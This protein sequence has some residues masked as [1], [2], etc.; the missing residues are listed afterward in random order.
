[1]KKERA[2][3]IDGNSFCYRAFYAIRTLSTSSGR[4]TNAVYGFVTM[5]QKLIHEEK[6]DYLAIA[7]DMKAETFRKKEFQDYKIH[8]KP[9]PDEL[10]EQLPV[11]QKVLGLYRIPIFQKEGYEADDVLGTLS[12]KLSAEGIAVYIVTGD[13]DILQLV[14]DSVFVYHSHKEGLI[15]DKK[16]VVE[17]FGIAPEKIVELIGLCG[18]SSDNIPGVPGV[19]E[20]TAVELIQKFGDLDRVLS[21]VDQVEGEARRRSLK[22]YSEQARLSRRLAVIDTEVPV[23]FSLEA[24]KPKEPEQEGLYARIRK[25]S[26]GKKKYILHDGPP[27]A[28]GHIHIGHA[29]NK[30]LKDM[31]VRFKSLMG[32]DS[33]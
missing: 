4:P 14:N 26:Q 30:I 10:V 11:I 25:Q 13:K 12:K 28:N 32:F 3:L 6:P 21:N 17:Q 8:R 1:M 2:F 15:Y 19:G 33:L 31:I 9:M 24:L 18:D 20:K 23:E 7:F 22:E 16:R 29:L 27:Y 5:L